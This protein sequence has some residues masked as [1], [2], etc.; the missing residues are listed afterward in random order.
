MLAEND[1]VKVEEFMRIPL[2]E[3]YGILDNKLE[4]IKK[5]EDARKHRASIH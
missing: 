4:Q 2:V 5:Q 3:Y 1:P